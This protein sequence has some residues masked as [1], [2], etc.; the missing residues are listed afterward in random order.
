MEE[1]KNDLEKLEAKVDHLK[2]QCSN[3]DIRI[4]MLEKSVKSLNEKIKEITSQCQEK[5]EECESECN[6]KFKE[7]KNQCQAEIERSKIECDKKVDEIKA[8]HQSENNINEAYIRRLEAFLEKS[9]KV[10]F[11]DKSSNLR[12]RTESRI[13]RERKSMFD[14]GKAKRGEKDGG[15]K[16]ENGFRKGSKINNYITNNNICI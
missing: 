6:K 2:L 5:I 8:L 12:K 11:Y 4:E 1:S 7:I 14:N 10:Y 15:K 13:N 16:S 3:K 9:K